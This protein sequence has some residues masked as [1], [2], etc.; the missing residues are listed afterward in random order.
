MKRNVYI[1][2]ADAGTRE[3]KGILAVGED[4]MSRV[5]TMLNN[6]MPRGLSVQSVFE[7]IMNMDTKARSC[8]GGVEIELGKVDCSSFDV[9]NEKVTIDTE[10][11][12]R[13]AVIIINGKGTK[14]CYRT[15]RVNDGKQ[16]LLSENNFNQYALFFPN[17][18][19]DLEQ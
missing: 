17:Q 9:V 11:S 4:V 7:M 13:L 12:T 19:Y 18:M 14:C 8:S 1:A 6:E 2:I 5:A 10:D 15:Y 3:C 16:E